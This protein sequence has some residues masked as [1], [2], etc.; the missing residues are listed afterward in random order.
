MSNHSSTNL[1]TAKLNLMKNKIL[2]TFA[3]LLPGLWLTAQVAINNDGSTPDPSAALDIKSTTQGI[4]IPR[5]TEAERLAIVQPAEG[6]MVYQTDNYFGFYFFDGLAW[7]ELGAT[8]GFA[9]LNDA[10]NEG[11]PGQGRIINASDSAVRISGTDGLYVTGTV[12]SGTGVEVSGAGTRMFFNPKSASFRSGGVTGSQWDSTNVGTYS[13]ATGYNTLA[14]GPSSVATGSNTQARGVSSFAT[15]E[16]TQANGYASTV[17]GVLND[18]LIETGSLYVDETPLFTVGNGEF[19]GL[20]GSNQYSN[21][22]VVRKKGLTQINGSMDIN[23]T[24]NEDGLY[25]TGTFG[26]GDTVRYGGAGT[27]MYFNP[28]RSAFRAGTVSGGQWN[29]NNVGN[30]TFASGYDTEAKADY[31]T[32]FGKQVTASGIHSVAAG[33]L[34]T[35]SGNAAVAMGT[36]ANANGDNAVAFGTASEASGDNSV[37]VGNFTKAKGTNAMAAGFLS[38]AKGSSSAALGKGVINK[39]ASSLVVGQYNDSILTTNQTTADSLTPLFVVGNGDGAGTR[40]NAMMVRK[41]GRVGVGTNTPEAK[42]DVNGGVKVGNSSATAPG[43]IRWT[44]TDFEGYNGTEWVSLTGGGGLSNSRPSFGMIQVA[45]SDRIEPLFTTTEYYGESVAVSDSTLLVGAWGQGLSNS[46]D[47]YFHHYSSNIKTF[48]T[49]GSQVDPLDNANHDYFGKTCDISGDYAIISAP[50]ADDLLGATEVGAVYVYEKSGNSWTE[51]HKFF[52][53][54]PETSEEF[55]TKM[56]ISGNYFVVGVSK[57]DDGSNVDEGVVRVY[58]RTSSGWAYQTTLKNPAGVANEKFGNQVDIS[59]DYI[60][61]TNTIS[62][63]IF[64]FKRNTATNTWALDTTIISSSPF[65]YNTSTNMRMTDSDIMIVKSD[66]V[67]FIHFNGA[68]WQMQSLL[69]NAGITTSSGGDLD[70]PAIDISGDIAVIGYKNYT[71]AGN[72]ESGIAVM[73]Q[74]TGTQWKVVGHLLPVNISAGTHFGAGVAVTSS[75]GTIAVGAPDSGSD[76]EVFL[77]KKN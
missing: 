61:V 66:T 19:G 31:S 53:L 72:S 27:R 39:G 4:L 73:F 15:G 20:F 9:T 38:Q 55:G 24:T 22:L 26:Q 43:T 32:A 13:L 76:G 58:E 44:G 35:A 68:S 8:A 3:F 75:L 54:T 2:L 50:G 46:G 41:D 74:R 6:L 10:Y 42:L 70:Y 77:Y 64:I 12:G 16:H 51:A 29:E 37:A 71:Y 56:A 67:E 23:G 63:N 14:S 49:I 57:E 1:F 5:M 21:A 25:V 69:T 33:N 11:G 48:Y 47:A 36:L 18:T 62:A 52:D 45:P 34:S 60:A 65:G 17:V 28:K 59:G 7:V 40:S 30:Y